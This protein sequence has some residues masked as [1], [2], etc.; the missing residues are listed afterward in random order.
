MD[1]VDGVDGADGEAEE[2]RRADFIFTDAYLALALALLVTGFPS[3]R[4][5]C[6]L[7]SLCFTCIPVVGLRK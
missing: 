5:L 6:F 3:P 4:E 1:G 2:E 7:T